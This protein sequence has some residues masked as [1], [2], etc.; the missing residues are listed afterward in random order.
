MQ[1]ENLWFMG[2]PNE[3]KALTQ[4]A[5]TEATGPDPVQSSKSLYLSQKINARHLRCVHEIGWRRHLAA[6]IG[7]TEN[8]PK[9]G[10]HEA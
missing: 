7:A 10:I 5:A 4:R 8:Q 2:T 3:D 9:A 1:R 6:T